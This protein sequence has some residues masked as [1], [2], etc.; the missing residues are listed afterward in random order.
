M[1]RGELRR[2]GVKLLADRGVETPDFEAL[3]LF[4]K[5][6]SVDRNACLLTQND[7]AEEEGEKVFL[8][9]IGKRLSGEPLQ[10]LL[11][12]WEFYGST[13]KVGPGVLIPRQETE[14]LVDIALGL[15]PEGRDAAVFDLCSGTGCV[16]LSFALRRPDCRVYPVEKYPEALGYLTENRD[17]LAAG[18]A[19][20]L[21]RDIFDGFRG[22]G[23]PFPD[24]I[25]CN[26]PYVTTGDTKHLSP[27][28]YRE[29][30][31][32]IDGGRDGL[33]F[34]R[35]LKEKWLPYVRGGGALAIECDEWQT[36]DIIEIFGHGE[37][38]KDIFNKKRYVVTRI[39]G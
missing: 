22:S 37:A 7:P 19:R 10:Y 11:G 38:V 24:L 16:G 20:I 9:L 13:F 5:A 21:G 36:D 12:E 32:A 2:R 18:N 4:Q 6:F 23:L 8:D 39:N 29:P 3:C 34:F 14:G 15:I 26:P 17:R 1:T 30:M 25:L 35:C 33:D 31:S 28:M 27:E